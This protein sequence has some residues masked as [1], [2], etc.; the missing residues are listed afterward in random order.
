MKDKISKA[1][2]VAWKWPEVYS[3]DQWVIWVSRVIAILMPAGLVALTIVTAVPLLGW[4]ATWLIVSVMVLAILTITIKLFY[5]EH[6][7]VEDFDAREAR[8]KDFF[9]GFPAYTDVPLIELE[10][11]IWVAYGHVPEDEFIN[12]IQTVVRNVTEDEEIVARYAHLEQSVGH[13]HA[14]F[15]NPAEGHWDEGIDLCKHTAK[16]AFPVTRVE[17]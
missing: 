7:T 5:S 12:A 1:Y 2:W 6:S 8:V 16:D 9:H 10:P 14:T 15:R 3:D 4:P 17:V 13:A 11:G